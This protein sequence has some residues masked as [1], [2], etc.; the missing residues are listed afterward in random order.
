MRKPAFC[1]C[2]NKGTDQLFGNR[3]ADQFLCFGYIDSTT[4]PFPK[5]EISSLSPSFVVVQLGLVRT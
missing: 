5:S 1:I 3:A 4:P 2:E